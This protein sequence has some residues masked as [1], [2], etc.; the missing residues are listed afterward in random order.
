MWFKNDR[1]YPDL[2]IEMHL[3]QVL[4]Y[5]IYNTLHYTAFFGNNTAIEIE[6]QAKLSKKTKD[7][8]LFYRR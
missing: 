5:N 4:Y 2:K 3:F 8:D 7:H 1:T 6:R